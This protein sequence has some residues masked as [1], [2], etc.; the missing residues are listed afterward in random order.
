LTNLKI[1]CN[2]GE[3]ANDEIVEKGRGK[4]CRLALERFAASNIYI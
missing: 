4:F 3:K 1:I 2:F